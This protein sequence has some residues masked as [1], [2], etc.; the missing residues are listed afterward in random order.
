MTLFIYI[1]ERLNIY[2]ARSEVAR[3]PAYAEKSYYTDPVLGVCAEEARC[4]QNNW[5]LLS[6]RKT[7]GN[8]FPPVFA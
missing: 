2:L 1:A 6:S 7:N 3:P 4:W 8:H 5:K